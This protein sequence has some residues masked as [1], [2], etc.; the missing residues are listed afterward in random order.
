MTTVLTKREKPKQKVVLVRPNRN[1][2]IYKAIDVS[3]PY[4]FVQYPESV[5]IHTS[6]PS[7]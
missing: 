7:V 6:D 3:L 4:K 2:S 1:L 5:R